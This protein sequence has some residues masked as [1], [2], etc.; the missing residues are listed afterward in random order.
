M[1]E[2]KNNDYNLDFKNPNKASVEH[3]F[4]LAELLGDLET[5]SNTI[6]GLVENLKRELEGVEE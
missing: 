1:D 3:E 6:L 5:R 2:I 4:S